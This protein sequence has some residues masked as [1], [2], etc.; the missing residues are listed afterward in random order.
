MVA[1]NSILSF[2]V[3]FGILS[4][5]VCLDTAYFAEIENLLLKIL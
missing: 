4:P 3:N 2:L 5:R 1:F